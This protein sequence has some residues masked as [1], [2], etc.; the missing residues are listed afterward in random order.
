MKHTPPDWLVI[1]DRT[2]NHTISIAREFK[3]GFKTHSRHI[4]S[5]S[6]HGPPEENAAN[7][8]LIAAAPDLLA[9]LEVIVKIC[10][11]NTVE[12]DSARAAI[13]KAKGEK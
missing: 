11:R 2:P 1:E 13:A 8:R 12:F 9:A 5:L 10:D 7:A 4:C 6:V 3:Q